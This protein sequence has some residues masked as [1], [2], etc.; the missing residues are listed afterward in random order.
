[1][2]SRDQSG[3]L[4]KTAPPWLND[5]NSTIIAYDRNVAAVRP[6]GNFTWTSAC[7]VRRLGQSINQ[8]IKFVRILGHVKN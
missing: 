5:R 7:D 1:V 3:G 6:S 8:S 4:S 2:K